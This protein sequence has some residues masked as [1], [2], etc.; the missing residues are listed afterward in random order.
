VASVLIGLYRVVLAAQ[1]VPSC[2]F[3]PSCSQFAL[4]AIE[5]AGSVR[6]V[7]LGADR[8]SRC[9]CLGSPQVG[10]AA[11]SRESDPV[12]WYVS[13]HP[14]LLDPRPDPRTAALLSAAVPGAGKMYAGRTADGLHSLAIVGTSALL[15]VRGFSRDGEA[16]VQGWTFAGIGALFHIANI[17]GSAIAADLRARAR[18][19]VGEPAPQPAACVLPKE[20]RP[21]GDSTPSGAARTVPGRRIPPALSVGLSAVIPGAGQAVCGSWGRGLGAL[22]LNAA[23]GAG[24]VALARDDREV[25]AGLLLVLGFRRYYVGNL[26]WAHRLAK[27]R[28]ARRTP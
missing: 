2:R 5:A 19:S 1:D 6:G 22:L 23:L 3:T 9:H 25:E 18:T 24:V 20:A 27:E 12:D 21:Q 28:N 10:G 14:A 7:L 16:S 15:A 13:R 8:L 17:Y 26:Y 11:T 4:E